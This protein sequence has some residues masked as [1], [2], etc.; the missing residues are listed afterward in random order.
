MESVIKLYNPLNEDF[1]FS[2]DKIPYTIKSKSYLDLPEYLARH[3]A[4]HLVN[5]IIMRPELWNELGITRK[6][7]GDV[8]NSNGDVV[9]EPDWTK[10]REPVEKLVINPEVKTEVKGED[11]VK[12]IEE[13]KIEQDKIEKIEKEFEDLEK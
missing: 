7:K 11:V 13:P 5:Y 10:D 3:G 6:D 12:K 9:N 2:W 4:K 8:R 1:T